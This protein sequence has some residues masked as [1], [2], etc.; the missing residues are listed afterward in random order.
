MG[1]PIFQTA[2]VFP[3]F[4]DRPL[5]PLS[6]EPRYREALLIVIS[7]GQAIGQFFLPALDVI[8]VELQ[9]AEIISRFGERLWQQH[10][11]RSVWASIADPP[12]P[13]PTTVSVVVCTRD[14]TD[15]LRLCIESL[16][17]LESPAHEILIVDNAPG[18]DATARLCAEYP[19]TYICEPLPGQSRA[20]NRGIIEAAGELVAFTDDDV[21][22]DACWLNELGREFSHNLVMAVTGYV[23]PREL[24]TTAQYLFELHGGFGRGFERREFDGA[25]LEPAM[26]A[27]PAGAG[28]NSI[29]RRSVFQE[30]GLF[31]EDLGPGTPA[32]AADD[33]D[34]FYR[35]LRGGYRIV[36]D[37]SRIVWHSHRR[38]E[39][40]LEKVLLDYT[41]SSFAF[42]T[43]CLV[44]HRDWG[45]SAS[46]GGGGGTTSRR[47]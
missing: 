28:A 1:R 41:V 25:W 24:E 26:A 7:E 46:P 34:A 44:R 37:P 14:R 40:G 30:V 36:F 13:V 29:F 27:G 2:K 4:L 8:P 16:L 17:E 11:E 18:D 35:I 5:A 33:N 47:T 31:S 42:V 21:V 19:V 9:R 23:G 32:R 38:D 45:R 20:R 12:S 39:K 22:V 10:L 43:R 3:V 15:D 6:V